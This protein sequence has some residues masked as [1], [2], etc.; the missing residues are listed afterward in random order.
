MAEGSIRGLDEPCGLDDCGKV[1][2]DHTMREWAEHV[3]RLDHDLPYE[4]IP[5][6]PIHLSDTDG[7]PLPVADN[8]TARASVMTAKSG[9]LDVFVPVLILEFA[10][11]HPVNGPQPVGRIGVLGPPDVMRRI[12]KLLRDSANGA[13]N[14][15]E[16]AGGRR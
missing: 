2:G 4:E 12:G 9:P 15:A 7:S 1:V 5:G 8:V 16:R 14:A 3:D 10:I 6:G 13:A 11:G